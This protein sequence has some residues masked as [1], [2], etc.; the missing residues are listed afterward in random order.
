MIH[1]S[2]QA[3]FPFVIFEVSKFGVA[4]REEQRGIQAG[5]ATRILKWNYYEELDT[6]N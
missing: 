5:K 6:K 4:T 3:R 1:N 2:Q